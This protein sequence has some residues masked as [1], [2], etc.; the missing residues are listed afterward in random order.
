MASFTELALTMLVLHT[1]LALIVLLFLTELVLTA[2]MLLTELAPTVLTLFL[3]EF[4]LAVPT[5]FR[6]TACNAKRT[7]ASR[8]T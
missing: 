1:E 3:T 6:C 5:F 8:N 2:L 7:T 4:A